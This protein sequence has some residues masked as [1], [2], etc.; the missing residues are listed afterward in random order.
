VREQAVEQATRA[1]RNLGQLL[2]PLRWGCTPWSPF[3]QPKPKGCG[4]E[5]SAEVRDLRG[6]NADRGRDLFKIRLRGDISRRLLRY[7]SA[8]RHWSVIRP[9]RWGNRP[10]FLWVGDGG[11]IRTGLGIQS[12]MLPYKFQ[13]RCAYDILTGNPFRRFS[14]FDF[15]F[16]GFAL[17]ISKVNA[18]CWATQPNEL[19]IVVRKLRSKSMCLDLT[20]IVIRGLCILPVITSDWPRAIEQARPRL[21]PP[22][23]ERPQTATLH[24][25]RCPQTCLKGR[26]RRLQQGWRTML[27]L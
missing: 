26:V 10:A 9:L 22:Q 8:V 2:A 14:D 25:A 27:T 6:P 21:R 11:V 20:K 23:T 17:E 15:S 7:V 4:F 3:I 18:E 19:E 16:F 5:L 1:L 12:E 24:W 13:V